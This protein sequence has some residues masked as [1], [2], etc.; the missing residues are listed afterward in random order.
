M[1][2]TATLGNTLLS[3]INSCPGK[4]EWEFYYFNSFLYVFIIIIMYDIFQS[5]DM[6]GKYRLMPN[7]Y[8]G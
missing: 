5:E 1:K 7:N 4:T 3:I 8:K 2:K 6:K